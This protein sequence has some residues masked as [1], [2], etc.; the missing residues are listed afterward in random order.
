[1]KSSLY[2]VSIRCSLSARRALRRLMSALLVTMLV[3]LGLHVA[4]GAAV[5][6]TPKKIKVTNAGPAK[7]W[8]GSVRVDGPVNPAV[9]ECQAV[10][11]DRLDLA[12][13]L[14]PGIWRHPGGVQ[15]AIRWDGATEAALGLYVYRGRTLVASS[16]AGVGLAQSVLI[17]SAANGM[18]TVYVSYGVTYGAVDPDPVIAYEGLAEVEFNPP[19]YPIRDLL[20]DLKS[21]PQENVTYDNPGTIFDD[22]AQPGQSC[23]DSER[24]EQGAVQCLRFDQV[25]QNVGAG[26]LELRFSRQAG[27]LQDEPVVQRV[28]R[29]DG[30]YTDRDAGFVE[31]HPVHGHYHFEGFAQSELWLADASGSP[32]GTAPA[33]TGDK[34]SFCVADTDLVTFGQK[35][36]APM[37]Y[38]AP[39]CLEPKLVEGAT[40]YFWYGMSRGWAD[41][42]NWYLP[43][44]FIDTQGLTDGTYVLYTRVDPDDKLQEVTE[45]DNCGSVVVRLTGLATAGPHA[46]LL[47]TG[48]ACV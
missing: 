2:S 7:F 31:F 1:M 25:L 44:Q 43:G 16:A 3:T 19:K 33:A 24:G 45:T 34:V 48:P 11:C 13:S 10:H 12:V 30:T 29:S 21:M 28:Y 5:A 8:T 15:V 9:P 22:T 41:R 42:Y 6:A 17:P 27:V 18:Y 20:P 40:E 37:S 46:D 32:V 35:G 23:F 4:P 47:G 38:P 36:D 14:P 39:D 26:P